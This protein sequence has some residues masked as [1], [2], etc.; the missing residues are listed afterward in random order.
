MTAPAEAYQQLR[1]WGFTDEEIAEAG[2]AELL[3]ADCKAT[4]AELEEFM[5]QMKLLRE[6]A[7]L[8]RLLDKVLVPDGPAKGE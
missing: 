1:D 6:M 2:G 3:L 8:L 5:K 7:R 4:F